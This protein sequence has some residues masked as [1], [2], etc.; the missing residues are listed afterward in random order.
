[1][2]C[3]SGS[4]YRCK[5]FASF[6][7]PIVSVFHVVGSGE[8]SNDVMHGFGNML[9]ASG[10]SMSGCW[11][12]GRMHGVCR[13]VSRSDGSSYEGSMVHG[14]RRG[15]GRL[16]FAWA[17]VYEGEVARDQP[18]GSG[19]MFTSAGARHANFLPLSLN[20]L[21]ATLSA[22]CSRIA[23]PLGQVCNRL[24]VC[25]TCD[26]CPYRQIGPSLS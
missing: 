6:I 18:N 8:W 4:S 21:Q 5:L 19:V 10:S 24:F 14:E 15:R 11:W 9:L 22:V 3:D 25:L 26:A 20:F 17:D 23:R 1:M 16:V 7:S 12:Q 2:L 13:H